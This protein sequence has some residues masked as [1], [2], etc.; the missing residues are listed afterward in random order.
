MAI[1]FMNK[2]NRGPKKGQLKPK[3]QW[4]DSPWRVYYPE[5]R[6]KSGFANRFFP[7]KNEAVAFDA[8]KKEERRTGASVDEK[9]GQQFI[10]AYAY[11]W[12]ASMALKPRSEARYRSVIR[13]HIIPFFGTMRVVDVQRTD[14]NT[15]I[16]TKVEKSYAPATIHGMYDVL[17]GMFKAAVIDQLRATTPCVKITNLPPIPKRSNKKRKWLPTQLQVM[18]LVRAFDPR[19]RLAVLVAAGCGLR[20]GEVMGLTV[21]DFDFDNRTVRVRRAL[22][23]DDCPC[24]VASCMQ[25]TK[26]V[27]SV[28]DVGMPARV[29]RAARAHIAAGY[30]RTLTMPDHTAEVK[31]GAPVAVR[32]MQMMFTTVTGKPVT[33]SRWSGLWRTAVGEAGKLLAEAPRGAAGFTLHTLRH[34]FGS[35]LIA[36]GANVVEVQEAMGHASPTVTL[37]EYVWPTGKSKALALVDD[38]FGDDGLDMAA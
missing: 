18:A 11:A 3:S 4:V 28:R 31:P 21:D 23:E 8:K 7:T 35:L 27:N 5:P 6:N 10:S 36:G 38:T 30:V 24:G 17:S 14:V 37:N 32:E 19:F 12:L 29:A 15:W 1:S 22:S 9:A 33:R 34:Y 25:T 26:S 2:Y 16:K 20:F 13:L